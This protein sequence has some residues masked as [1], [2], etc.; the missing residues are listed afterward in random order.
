[1]VFSAS[2][3]WV[4]WQI[5]RHTAF[6]G[7]ER[8]LA[9]WPMAIYGLIQATFPWS[10]GALS[11]IAP[12]AYLISSIT[13]LAFA[14]GLLMVFM[15]TAE[16]EVVEGHSRLSRALTRALAGHVDMCDRC[17]S[18]RGP[19]GG[20]ERVEVH[21]GH[22]SGTSFSHSICPDCLETHYGRVRSN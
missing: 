2:L 9:A 14:L 22:R 7:F 1:M 13:Q 6:P 3:I 11:G 10:S 4:A 15:R 5:G 12:A 18:V 17:K 20:W 8:A 16:E 19:G 21:V